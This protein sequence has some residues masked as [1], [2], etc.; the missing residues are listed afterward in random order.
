[1]GR[2]A[3]MAISNFFIWAD[4]EGETEHL[5]GG[6][7]SEDG[8][9]TLVIHQR[10]EGG[11]VTPINIMGKCDEHGKLELKV[12]LHGECVGLYASER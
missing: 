11:V 2:I 5:S 7:M 6:P 8:G 9:F 10:N 12:L 1:M 4:I 3:N